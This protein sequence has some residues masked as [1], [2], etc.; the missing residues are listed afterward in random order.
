M[1]SFLFNKFYSY[2]VSKK[3][4]TPL[5][6]ASSLVGFSILVHFFIIFKLFNKKFYYSPTESY[7]GNKLFYMPFAVLYI[8]LIY[9]FFKRRIKKIKIGKVSTLYFLGL[10]LV[11]IIVPLCFLIFLSKK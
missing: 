1:Y 4:D 7:M 5:W 9:T 8:F 6:H 3:T 2:L 10:I 11:F